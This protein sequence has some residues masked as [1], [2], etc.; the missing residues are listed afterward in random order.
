[1][2][3]KIDKIKFYRLVA[4]F[5]NDTMPKIAHTSYSEVSKPHGHLLKWHS[6]VHD[7]CQAALSFHKGELILTISSGMDE[8]EHVDNSKAHSLD[9]NALLKRGTLEIV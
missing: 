8:D 9:L 2:R 4:H 3:I 1:M 7:K 6:V 5:V